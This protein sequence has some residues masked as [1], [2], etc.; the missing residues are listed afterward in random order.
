MLST[1]LTPLDRKEI[2]N[3]IENPF[4]LITTQLIEAG[5][6]IS[7]HEVIRDIAPLD[8]LIQSAGRCNRNQESVKGRV[9]I[10]ELRDDND[11]LLS[12]W[13]YSSFLIETTLEVLK[14]H[15]KVDESSYHKLAKKYYQFI[16]DRSDQKEILNSLSK[17]SFNKLEGKEGLQLIKDRAKQPYFIIQNDEDK[18]IWD[19]YIEIKN[20]EI[21]SKEDF[22]RRRQRY[23]NIKRDFMERIVNYPIKGEV[24]DEVIPIYP[25]SKSYD[26]ECGLFIDPD[27]G[28]EFL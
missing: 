23:R 26:P 10:I 3:S 14:E 24:K 22:Y 18:R 4:L 28:F 25:D 9:E 5:V 15:T 19:R 6:D 17:G 21:K 20:T 13:V 2:L 8:C 12:T 27:C 11:K 16:K 7:A 1:D